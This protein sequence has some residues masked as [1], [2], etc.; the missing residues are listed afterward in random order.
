MPFERKQKEKFVVALTILFLFLFFQRLA[1]GQPD[2]PDV[3]FPSLRGEL[4]HVIEA[5]PSGWCFYL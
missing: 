4:K 1:S 2:V 3:P 5:S